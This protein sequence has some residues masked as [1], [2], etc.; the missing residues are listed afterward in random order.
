MSLRFRDYNASTITLEGV[1][2]PESV[3]LFRIS[4][5]EKQEKIHAYVRNNKIVFVRDGHMVMDWLRNCGF[6]EI[7][8]AYTPIE[9]W[10]KIDHAFFCICIRE[11]RRWASAIRLQRFLRWALWKAR[12]PPLENVKAFQH[13]TLAAR[14]PGDVACLIAAACFT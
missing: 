8:K 4:D 1:I 6:A 7:I 2:S 3:H 12:K 13:T 9:G 11:I 14:L 5:A 10:Y